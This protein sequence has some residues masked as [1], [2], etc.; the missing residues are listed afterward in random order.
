MSEINQQYLR[1]IWK[2]QR[3]NLNNWRISLFREAFKLRDLVASKAELTNKTFREFDTNEDQK[4]VEAI[5]VDSKD[6]KV[7]TLGSDFINEDAIG[8]FRISIAMDEDENTYPK[9]YYHIVVACKYRKKKIEFCYWDIAKN[10][11]QDNSNW[12]SDIDKFADHLLKVLI[13]Y[14]KFD[15][16]EGLDRPQSIGFVLGE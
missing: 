15:I 8:R 7:L 10:M 5:E 2:K 9:N 3:A 13:D 16:F 11:P 12:E 4:Y 6:R 14:F 1:D